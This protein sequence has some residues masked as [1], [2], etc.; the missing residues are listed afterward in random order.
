MQVEGAKPTTS[1]RQH[2]LHHTEANDQQIARFVL[3]A[4]RLPLALLQLDS[5]YDFGADDGTE[6]RVGEEEVL[7]PVCV[8]GDLIRI[9]VERETLG[10]ERPVTEVLGFGSGTVR[11]ETII[12]KS[13]FEDARAVVGEDTY[14]V[15]VGLED[16]AQKQ[17]LASVQ[18]VVECQ[19]ISVGM[20]RSQEVGIFRHEKA[21]IA[22]VHQTR[23]VAEINFAVGIAEVLVMENGGVLH[24]LQSFLA[25]IF[26]IVVDDASR[27]SIEAARVRCAEVKLRSL[28]LN[29]EPLGTTVVLDGALGEARSSLGRS[30]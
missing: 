3:S 12:F 28:R 1:R 30:G 15:G 2:P 5:L 21:D 4:G 22:M 11:E 24:V 17:A 16:V 20:S 26:D 27:Q 19:G 8:S 6:R 7:R 25:K 23:G 13:G 14:I 10:G 18:V 29:V 9:K